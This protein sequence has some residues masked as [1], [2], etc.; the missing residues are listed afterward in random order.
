MKITGTVVTR[1]SG[2]N[3]PEW[4]VKAYTKDAAG[5]PIRY[6]PADYY[7]SGLQDAKTTAQAMIA[8]TVNVRNP[9]LLDDCPN[10]CTNDSCGNCPSCFEAS[11]GVGCNHGPLCDEC[12]MYKAAQQG[13]FW[14]KGALYPTFAAFLA[15]LDAE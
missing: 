5:K 1:V 9:D 10:D 6:E 3:P 15:S 8:M 14:S 7:A 4:V 11:D 2:S 13:L 12:K